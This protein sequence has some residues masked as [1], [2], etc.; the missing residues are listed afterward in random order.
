MLDALNQVEHP[1]AALAAGCAFTAGFVLEE[2]D[3]LIDDPVNRNGVVNH[4]DGSRPEVRA[5]RP[6]RGV[7]HRRVEGLVV[8]HDERGGR[9]GRH[10]GLDRAVV[11]DAAAILV[12][13]F[14]EGRAEG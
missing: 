10:D 5:E 9:A 11:Y 12:N 7:V 13:Q 6:D 1:I 2:V 14:A 8:R 3:G 4:D